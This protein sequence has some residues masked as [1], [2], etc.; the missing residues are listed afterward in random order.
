FALYCRVIHFLCASSSLSDGLIG[1]LFAIYQGVWG[2]GHLAT[3][4]LSDR[5]GR[6]HLVVWGMTIQGVALGVIA[7]G[8]GFGIWAAGAALLGIGTAMVYP[9]L[10]AVVGDVRS[11]EHT[12]E[13]QSRFDLVCRLLLEKKNDNAYL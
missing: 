5:V 8:H 2:L 13:L 4:A 3:A 6:K 7:A 11:E 12:S 9:T 10:L 1:L